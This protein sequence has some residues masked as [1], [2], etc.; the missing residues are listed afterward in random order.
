MKIKDDNKINDIYAATLKLVKASGLAG[1][2]MQAVAKEAGVATGTLYIYFQ[3]KDELII[4]L[5]DVCVK[6][7]ASNFFKD[8]SVRDPFKV[9]FRTIWSNILQHR[10]SRF[11]E[12]IFIEQCFHSPFI[13]EDTKI[14]LKKMF[15]PLLELLNRGKRE[16]L[17][18]NID[19][20]WL[21]TFMI[22]GINEVAKRVVYFNKKLSVELMDQNFQMCWDG[23]KA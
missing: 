20:F 23:I 1:I 13:D 22:G 2:T 9:G 11:P 18:K 21:L 7:S 19:T 15:D 8:Y 3:N 16:H 5:F 12:S 14:T 6:N 4:R 17:I 10:L